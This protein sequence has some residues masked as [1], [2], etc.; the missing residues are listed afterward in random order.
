MESP[1]AIQNSQESLAMKLHKLAFILHRYIGVTMGLLLLV[2]GLTGSSLVF[3]KEID[4]ARNLPLMQVVPQGE[5][6]SLDSIL[7][8][9]QSAYPNLKL[10]YIGLPRQPEGTYEVGMESKAEKWTDVY[11][12]PY[13]GAILGSRQWDHSLMGIV[14]ELHYTLLAGQVG[15]KVIGVCGLL[16]LLLGIT[17]L[18][19]W[20]GWR[21]LVAGFKIRWHSP[22][23]LVNYDLHKVVGIL[24]I[25]FLSLLAF[26]GTVMSFYTE[27]EGAVY[28][29]TGTPK[30]QVPTS[31]LVAGQPPTSLDAILHKADAALPGAATTYI[32][33]SGEP[34]GAVEVGK[35]FS[36]EA[37]ETGR[38]SVYLDRHSGEI[39]RVENAFKVPLA[40]RILNSQL[41]LHNGSYGGL[42]MRI[43]YVFIGLTPAALFITGLTLWWHRQWDKAHRHEAVRQAK[44]RQV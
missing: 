15:E 21:R 18:I 24:A 9:V 4:H 28:W 11:V 2:I 32:S 20:P 14:Y 12:N 42:S 43:L 10:T 1:K 23:R 25:V 37:L 34:D 17:G 35:K 44:R 30:P 13:T 41:S 19:L 31:T 22:S 40:T 29:L 16:L 38:S 33:L 6:V 26:T 3:W 7:K 36:Q 5:R 39:L 8:P 27:F